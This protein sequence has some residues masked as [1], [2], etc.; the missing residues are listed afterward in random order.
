MRIREFILEELQREYSFKPD[1]DVDSI[2]YVKEG[3]MDSLSIVQFVVEIEDEFGI[4]FTN[5]EMESLDFCI[6]GKLIKMV[7]NKVT[8]IRNL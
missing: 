4:E 7:E 6:V 1:V 5:E 2:N 8:N 3:Y